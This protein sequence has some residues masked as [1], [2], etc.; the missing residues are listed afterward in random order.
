VLSAHDRTRRY[1]AAQI[2]H[3]LAVVAEGGTITEAAK[4]VGANYGTVREWIEQAPD[5]SSARRALARR[6]AHSPDGNLSRRFSDE[7]KQHA[8]RLV[9]EQG[10]SLR[11]AAAAVGASCPTVLKWV[12]KAA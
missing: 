7:Q 4:A 2:A 9:T 12:R 6:R 11:T 8:I 1:S 10:R 5:G 3:A